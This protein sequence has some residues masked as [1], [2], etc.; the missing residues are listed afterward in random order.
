MFVE[1]PVVF[2]AEKGGTGM[3]VVEPRYENAEHIT[4][5]PFC[6]AQIGHSVDVLVKVSLIPHVN[7]SK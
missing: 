4:D 7:D 5:A 3:G 2:L 1:D 6:K